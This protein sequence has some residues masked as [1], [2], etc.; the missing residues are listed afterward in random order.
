MHSIEFAEPWLLLLLL[1]APVVFGLS[2]LSRGRVVYS[3]L[4]LLPAHSAS[5]RTRLAWLPDALLALAVVGFVVAAAGPRRGEE[6]AKIRREGIAILCAIDISGSMMALDL[7]PP[8]KEQ[9]R[10][11]AVKEAFEKFVL[12]GAN[13]GGRPD[14]AIGLVSFARYADTRSPLTLDHANLI[15]AARQLQIVSDREEDG[16]A[17]GAGLALGVERLRTFKAKSKVL[18]LLTDGV[19]N[20]DEI[21]IDAAIDEARDGKVKVYTI[22]AGTNGMAAVRVPTGDGGS[23]LMQ[24]QVQIDEQT[25][26]EIADK[27]GG[28]YFRVTDNASLKSVYAQ[29]DALERTAIEDTRFA[30]YEQLFAAVLVTALLLL[31]V[32]LLLRATLFRRVP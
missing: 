18:V 21:S 4:N 32:G 30:N 22:G 5:W 7:S 25:L 26:T 19:Q 2:Y 8:K 6:N 3:S 23:Q 14:D 12:G 28:K 27:T 11:D 15:A 13:L 16:T 31:V 9:T 24:T 10:L 20:F 29:I 17:I 1:L